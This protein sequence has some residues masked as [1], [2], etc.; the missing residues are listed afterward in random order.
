MM[1][2]IK[3]MTVYLCTFFLLTAMPIQSAHAGWSDWVFS[4]I[5]SFN[6]WYYDETKEESEEEIADEADTTGAPVSSQQQVADAQTDQAAAARLC[7]RGEIGVA[8]RGLEAFKPAACDLDETKKIEERCKCVREKTKTNAYFPMHV[9]NQEQ[10]NR[11]INRALLKNW[12]RKKSAE[13]KNLYKDAARFNNVL[14][15]SPGFGGLEEAAQTDLGLGSGACIPTNFAAMEK[16]FIGAADGL[17]GGALCP[18]DTL[19]IVNHLDHPKCKE[20]ERENNKEMCDSF[21]PGVNNKNPEVCAKHQE[22]E[23]FFKRI[24]DETA[25]ELSDIGAMSEEEVE[26]LIE[27]TSEEF[28]K[29]LS[30]IGMTD[31]PM[32]S[33]HASEE[34]STPEQPKEE[35]DRGVPLANV[36]YAEVVTKKDGCDTP[37]CRGRLLAST[38]RLHDILGGSSDSLLKVDMNKLT[39][40]SLNKK[41]RES[42]NAYVDLIQEKVKGLGSSGIGDLVREQFAEKNRLHQEMAACS[43]HKDQKDRA[44][45]ISV[46]QIKLLDVKDPLEMIMSE[47]PGMADKFQRLIGGLAANDPKLRAHKGSAEGKLSIIRSVLEGMKRPLQAK[48]D[49]KCNQAKELMQKVCRTVMGAKIDDEHPA[50]NPHNSQEF[51]DAVKPMEDIRKL[52]AADARMDKDGNLNLNTSKDPGLVV[53]FNQLRCRAYDN[54]NRQNNILSARENK[55]FGL[56]SID[57]REHEITMAANGKSIKLSHKGVAI[58]TFDSTEGDEIDPALIGGPMTEQ[59]AVEKGSE[60]C[61]EG[62][63]LTGK[64]NHSDK[65]FFA[66]KYGMGW[67]GQS[68]AEAKREVEEPL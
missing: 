51:F 48:A 6:D 49:K 54:E 28:S 9:K 27:T 36:R 2:L 18:V 10:I 58:A 16:N 47:V 68:I 7:K 24:V 37:Q 60:V 4:P 25:G 34:A 11:D 59:Q 19:N 64:S 20:G 38:R 42:V 29:T 32:G 21:D 31:S 63:F 55:E 8:L 57:K 23:R 5:D 67:T 12:I 39:D 44:I 61:G 22:N 14:H 1:K 62:N 26:G 56:I 33:K 40:L 30:D 53:R 45:C 3:N 13:V 43:D 66:C 65:S 35:G 15:L 17:K 52:M 50:I 41:N 46:T